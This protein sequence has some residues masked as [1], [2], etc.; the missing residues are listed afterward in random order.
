MLDSDYYNDYELLD[1]DDGR[2]TVV[3]ENVSE[4]EI[5][6]EENMSFEKLQE[7]YCSYY[8]KAKKQGFSCYIVGQDE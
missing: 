8:E 6:E 3:F 1:E 4:K 7:K 5:F 2:I